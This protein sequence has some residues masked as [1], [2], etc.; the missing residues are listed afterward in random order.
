MRRIIASAKASKNRITKGSN[1]PFSRDEQ[2]CGHDPKDD[3]ED[4]EGPGA[5]QPY[6][7]PRAVFREFLLNSRCSIQL[8]Q[9]QPTADDLLDR[10]S[11]V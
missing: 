7:S 1:A 4:P 9:D 11:V 6:R 8:P 3:F 10:K 2:R 5:A